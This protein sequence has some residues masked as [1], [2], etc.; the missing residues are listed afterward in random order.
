[1]ARI[2]P[3]IIGAF[4]LGVSTPWLLQQ[5]GETARFPQ[6]ILQEVTNP[7]AEEQQPQETVTNTGYDAQQILLIANGS[8]VLRLSLQE[9]LTGVVLAEMGPAFSQEA[10][11]AQA[12]VARTYTLRRAERG[13]RHQGATVC[14]DSSCCQAYKSPEAYLKAGGTQAGLNKVQQAVDSTD[15]LVLRYKG[16]LIDATYFSC[17]GGSTE[18]AVAVWGSD[19]PYLQ[20][21]DS[22]GEED[23]PRYSDK[24]EFTAKEFQK[25]LG[26]SL[27][28]KPSTWFSKASYTA[29]GGVDK[30]KIGGQEYTG[31]QLRTLLKLRSTAFTVYTEGSNIIL[32]TR[33]YGHRVGM[34]Q[35][36]AEAMAEKGEDYKAILYHYYQGVVLEAY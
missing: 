30:I 7:T 21:T 35:Y 15:G 4:L 36:G 2:S 28:G 23:A 12:V 5:T 8:G 31:K 22:P 26:R 13:G 24:V 25:A 1:M 9:Y 27:S 16:T 34:S 11:K 32:E 29:G 10:L 33:G 6:Q 18:D 14:T 20:A 3:R 17:S 19:V